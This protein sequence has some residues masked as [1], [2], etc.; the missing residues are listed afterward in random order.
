MRKNVYRVDAIIISTESRSNGVN[1]YESFAANSCSFGFKRQ[2]LGD[3][4][5]YLLA[6][7][8]KNYGRSMGGVWEVYGRC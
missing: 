7:V 5:P 4:P 1:I 6:S 2:K 8:E 3:Y